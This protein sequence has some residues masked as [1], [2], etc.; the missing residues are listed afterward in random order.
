MKEVSDPHAWIA[1]SRLCVYRQSLAH[2][3]IEHIGSAEAVLCADRARL[4]ALIGG[5]D[6]LVT[7]IAEK[8]FW[9]QSRADAAACANLR[10]AVIPYDDERYPAL[11]RMIP[12]PPLVLYVRGADALIS[13]H[14]CV[15]LVGARKASR[16][17][18]AR[19]SYLARDL[20]RRGVTVVSGMAFGIDAAAHEGALAGGG[21][22]VA[23]WGTGP[24]IIYPTAH[25]RL[26]ARIIEHGAVVT[27]FPPGMRGY[28][29]HFPQRNRIISGLALG[30]VVVEAAE[31]SG[32]LITAR[33]ALDQGREVMCMPGM[34]G[35]IMYRGG[36][37]LLREG[38]ALV[39]S[40][41]DVIET[42]F[43]GDGALPARNNSGHFKNP[44][45]TEAPLNEGGAPCHD[46][47]SDPLLCHVTDHPL[48]L[49]ALIEVSG[50]SAAAVLERVT[51]LT[52]EGKIE[53]LPGK[54]FTLKGEG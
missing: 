9:P 6:P 45:A 24:D 53:E 23:V 39:E 46:E 4:A 19:A 30:V 52:L 22:T 16:E 49:D 27:E 8:K 41:D 42:L 43:G 20:A 11:M 29:S 40:A 50:M 17:G 14:P 12:A 32:S 51:T 25:T 31:K 34:S 47:T 15:A 38:A 7:A 3:L 18:L 21:A 1:L 48:S 33:I 26:A 2:R 28:A 35:H 36:N 37:R 5:D 13:E 44:S 10:I 54:R